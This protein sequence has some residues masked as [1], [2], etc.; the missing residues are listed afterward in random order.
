MVEAS[1]SGFEFA[2]GDIVMFLDADDYL[3]ET[4]IESVVSV[5]NESTV[6]VHFRLR[7]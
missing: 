7:R 4:A 1:N 2:T 5:W 6:K 3:K